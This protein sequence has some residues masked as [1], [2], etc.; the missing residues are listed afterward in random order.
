MFAA[1]IDNRLQKTV[2]NFTVGGAACSAPSSPGVN[3]CL[4]ASGSTVNSPV[5]VEADST[6]T[7]TIARMELWVDGVKMYSAP[8]ST[9]LNTSISVAAGSHRFSVLAINTAGQKWANAVDA[10]VE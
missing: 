10:T 2:F 1:D 3:I 8:S 6:V 7:G 4:P 9:V 5:Q